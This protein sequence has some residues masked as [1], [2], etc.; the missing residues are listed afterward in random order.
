MRNEAPRKVRPWDLLQTYIPFTAPSRASDEDAATRLAICEGCPQLRKKTD[1][2]GIKGSCSLCGCI[3]SQK[4][5]LA[6]AS[7][8]FNPPKWGPV[9]AVN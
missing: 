2:H 6:E 8:P 1:R 4:S 7:C 3:M 9:E 5:K